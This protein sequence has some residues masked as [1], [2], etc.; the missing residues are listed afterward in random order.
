VNIDIINKQVSKSLG[1]KET[2]VTQINKFFWRS[3]YD[4]IYSYNPMPVNIPNVC[5]IY[6]NPYYNKQEINRYIQAIRK[7]KF[8]KRYKEGSLMRQ[9]AIEEIK[10]RLRK[11]LNIRKVNK[12]TN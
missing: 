8:N 1:I 7:L 10:G 3:V 2:D 9:K 4:H 11:S 12:W 6:P 5:V